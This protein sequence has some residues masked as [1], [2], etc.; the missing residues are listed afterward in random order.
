MDERL[1]L[2]VRPRW[3]TAG[4]RSRRSSPTALTSLV[5]TILLAAGGGGAGD[6]FADVVD[7]LVAD[8][9]ARA[10]AT[11]QSANLESGLVAG[12]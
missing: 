7:K 4:W 8:A 6:G 12:G 3:L 2:S 5:P 11:S 9:H 10:R 1:K